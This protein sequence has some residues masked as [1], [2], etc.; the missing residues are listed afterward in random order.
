VRQ[1]DITLIFYE[2]SG[3][4]LSALI[5]PTLLRLVMEVGHK[6]G[7]SNGSFAVTGI[8]TPVKLNVDE[9]NLNPRHLPGLLGPLT[10]IPANSPLRHPPTSPATA[11]KYKRMKWFN[12]ERK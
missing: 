12:N 11:R 4:C 3:D 7:H 1:F 2:D 8:L 10:N 6:I 5:V 9:L